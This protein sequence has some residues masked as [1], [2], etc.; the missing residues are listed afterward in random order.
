[1]RNTR[2]GIVA[3][4]LTL[5]AALLWCGMSAANGQVNQTS[6]HEPYTMKGFFVRGD[7]RVPSQIGVPGQT[8][9][10]GP[11][12]FQEIAPCRVI[13]T[14]TADQYPAQWGGLSFSP[15]EQR[16]Y[17]VTGVLAEG[18]FVNPCSGQIPDTARA[19]GIRMLIS[20]PD[21]QGSVFTAPAYMTYGIPWVDS[22]K[23]MHTL[24]FQAGDNIMEEGGVMVGDRTI[25]LQVT[26]ATTDLAVEVLG[27]FVADT[28]LQNGLVGPQ[29]PQGVPGESGAQGPAGPTGPAGVTGSQGELGPA[30]PTGPA[31]ADGP[32]GPAGP[33]GAPGPQGELGPAGPTGPAGTEG[34]AGPVGPAGPTGP[35]GS[36]GSTGPQGLQGPMGPPGP[37]GPQ[38]PAGAGVRLATG[39]GTFPGGSEQPVIFCGQNVT[40]VHVAFCNY[41]EEGSSGNTC[42][43]WVV[44]NCVY[45]SGSPQKT[46][47]WSV[48]SLVVPNP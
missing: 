16:I 21:A 26:N 34:P 8:A 41:T 9:D 18:N 24:D 42:S 44:G 28:L 2:S 37:Q 43:A 39:T 12:I 6:P 19:L 15:F 40:S 13:S 46:Y 32:A 20:N 47:R 45:V 4:L 38:G 5:V 30:G 1:M 27:Y 48:F 31:G 25:A 35:A 22:T 36:E 7:L 10:M 23:K 3:P 11:V 17:A 14:F 33:A 29:G